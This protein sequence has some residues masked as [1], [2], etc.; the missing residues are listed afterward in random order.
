V[1]VSPAALETEIKQ[2]EAR[3]IDVFS[4]LGVSESC[5]VILPYHAALDVARERARGRK[6]IGTT[7]RGIGPAYEDKVARRGLRFDELIESR[8]FAEKLEQVMDYHNF[9]L[10]RL[11]RGADRRLPRCPGRLHGAP[12]IP[13]AADDQ[14]RDAPG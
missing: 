13:A 6:A 3:G 9:M 4:R 1:V 12:G 8:Q 7:G 14:C 11:L 10:E 2:L 5:P